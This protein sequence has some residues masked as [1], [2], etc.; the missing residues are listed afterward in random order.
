MK[1]KK[2]EMQVLT[3][4]MYSSNGQVETTKDAEFFASWFTE[5]Y[6]AIADKQITFDKDN[7]PNYIFKELKQLAAIVGIVRWFKENTIP[8]DIDYE[9]E[10]FESAS[11]YT[12]MI[13]RSETYES[14]TI[15]IKITGGVTL[16]LGR[17]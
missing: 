13:S 12:P 9:P 11:Y 7:N 2:V 8:I 15:Y 17:S 4:T 6:D 5:N 16:L 10:Y 1:I 3:E 14:G